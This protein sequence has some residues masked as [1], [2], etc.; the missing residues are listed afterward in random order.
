[1]TVPDW[2]LNGGYGHD[3]IPTPPPPPT[4]TDDDSTETTN[5]GAQ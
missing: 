5:G 4:T 1:M 2:T 3:P